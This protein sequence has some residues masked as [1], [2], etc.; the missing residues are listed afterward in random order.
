MTKR[1]DF[2]S[3]SKPGPRW[4]HWEGVATWSY[5]AI[6]GYWRLLRT[7]CYKECRNTITTTCRSWLLETWRGLC[8]RLQDKAGRASSVRW[9]DILSDLL[10]WNERV[11]SWTIRWHLARSYKYLAITLSFASKRTII[12]ASSLLRHQFLGKRIEARYFHYCHPHVYNL[13]WWKCSI[14]SGVK[15]KN[16]ELW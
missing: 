16:L 2:G 15:G 9:S 13:I 10:L 14:V 7:R 11:L 3:L 1:Y 12:K 5:L 6:F 4:W 8:W